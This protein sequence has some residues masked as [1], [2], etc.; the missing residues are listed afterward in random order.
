VGWKRH[1]RGV[2]PGTAGVLKAQL[3]CRGFVHVIAL[4]S[5]THWSRTKEVLR[6]RESHEGVYG[7]GVT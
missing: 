3:A 6:L 4:P 1:I 7:Q 2:G 5:L